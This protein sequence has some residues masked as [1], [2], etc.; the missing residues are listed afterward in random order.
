MAFGTGS[1][2][3]VLL[4]EDFR[5][6]IGHG[7]AIAGVVRE[8]APRAEIHALKIFDRE[9][10]A[11]FLVLVEALEW[12][13]R[14]EMKLIH[15]SLGSTEGSHRPGLERLCR[16]A[17]N[18]GSLI[19]ASARSVDDRVYPSVFDS[20][21][22][23]CK[24][25]RCG[26]DAI[27]HYPGRDVNFGAHGSPRPIPGLPQSRNFYGSSFAAARV[28]ALAAQLLCRSPQSSPEGI[29]EELTSLSCKAWGDGEAAL[30]Q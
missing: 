2:G 16:L 13:I 5:D 4:C 18:R 24:D 17:R 14:H 6:E 27:V 30:C 19:V 9:L 12:A 21:I 29:F 22:G 26:P 7:T 8:R 28:T 3:D 15:L 11:P 20:V 23:V 25:P 1:N 10:R